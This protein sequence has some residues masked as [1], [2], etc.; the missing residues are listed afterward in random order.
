M[1]LLRY[2]L[3]FVVFCVIV[4]IRLSEH[5]DLGYVEGTSGTV[6]VYWYISY[7]AIKLEDGDDG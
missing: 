6:T 2:H 3:S 1:I 4:N 5:M 7:K